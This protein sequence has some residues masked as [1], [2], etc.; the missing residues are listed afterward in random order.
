M[1]KTLGAALVAAVLVLGAGEARAQACGDFPDVPESVYDT[2]VDRVAPAL[3]IDDAAVCEKFTKAAVA[4]CHKAVSEMAG[5]Y[6]GLAGG[7]YKGLKAVCVVFKNQSGCVDD[8]KDLLDEDEAEI[9][10]AAANAHAACDGIL[11]SEIDDT[12]MNGLP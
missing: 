5:C 11:A 6:D 10:E 2:F 7:L 1:T 3:P 8:A 9:E 4:A 12:C